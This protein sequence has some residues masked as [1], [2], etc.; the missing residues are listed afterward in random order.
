M[1]DNSQHWPRCIAFVDMDA[2]FASIEQSDHPEYRGRPIGITNGLTGT[3]LITCSYEARAYG[4]HIGMR[5]KKARTLCP[6]VIQV[7][8]RPERYARV[9]TNIMAALQGITPDVEVFSVDEAYLD[10]T[11]CQG[12][13]NLSPEA[14]GEMIRMHVHDVCKLPCTVGISGDKTTA[15]YAAKQNKPNGLAII[16]PWEAQD[17]LKNIPVIE[18]C[19]VNRGIAG[20]LARRGAITCGEV[21]KLPVSVLGDRFGNPGRRI[22]QMCQGKDPAPVET[23]I[24]TPKSLGHGKIMPPDTKDRDIIYMYLVHMAEKLG[25]RLRQH[26]LVAQKYYAGLR[27]L[28]GWIGDN[29]LKTTFPTNDSRPLIELC[30]RMIEECWHEEGVFQVQVSALDPRPAKGQCEL[31]EEED[32]YHKL[33]QVMDAINQRYGEFTL[34]RASLMHRSDMP[35]VIAPAWK[36]YG[37]RQTIVLTAEKKKAKS[38][39]K[40][41]SPVDEP[42]HSLE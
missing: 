6:E 34:T 9:S 24:T 25:T 36:P 8:S 12:Y 7:A 22:W 33:N 17:R 37:H 35:N 4:I 38:Q 16:P 32:R 41:A 20:F 30:D 13:W 42:K 27:T 40:P 2:F 19:G 23:R 15:K 14:M 31:F 5:L 11:H 26:S 39:A 1:S 29:R 18:L 21:A 3:C 28:E 10:L